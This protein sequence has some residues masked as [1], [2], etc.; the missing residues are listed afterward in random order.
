MLTSPWV[1]TQSA[2]P[3]NLWAHLDAGTRA[4]PQAGELHMKTFRLF[5]VVAGIAALAACNVKDNT[6]NA[7]NA[8]MNADVNAADAA[9]PPADLNADMNTDMNAGTTNDV[10]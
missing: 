7:A 2:R 10:A 8:D 3:R 1:R 6:N 4:A 9:L 5:V